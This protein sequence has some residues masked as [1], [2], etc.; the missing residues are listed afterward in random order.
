M[1]ERLEKAL[2]VANTLRTYNNQKELLKEEYKE[3]LQYHRDGCRFTVTRELINFLV[4]L[5]TLENT[6]DVVILDDFENPYMIQDV[7][8][9]KN[10]LINIY[11]TTTN[12]YY[13]DFNKLKSSR[14]I[15]KMLELK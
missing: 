11:F 15:E 2:S 3:A 10:E 5:A 14:S 13:Y 9:F 6:S 1:D 8:E 7:N 4:S 12:R